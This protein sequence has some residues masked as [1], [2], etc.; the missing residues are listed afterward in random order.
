MNDLPLEHQQKV[1]SLAELIPKLCYEGHTSP[2]FCIKPTIDHLLHG[3]CRKPHHPQDDGLLEVDKKIKHSLTQVNNRPA[4]LLFTGDQI[5]VDHV[6]GPLLTAIH[7]VIQVLG[8]FDENW[9]GAKVANQTELIK[10]S[11]CYYQREQ[12]LP[13]DK[14][15]Q[16]ALD[17]FFWRGS[18]THFYIGGSSQSFNQ[19]VRNYRHVF[20]GMVRYSLA[21][22]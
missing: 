14:S 12:L 19:L 17:I 11:Q 10:S 21:M 1:Q 9:S 4:L 8:L 7:Q 3:S 16:S 2:V 5:Y 22:G 20:A 13:N 6:A 15:A 18:K